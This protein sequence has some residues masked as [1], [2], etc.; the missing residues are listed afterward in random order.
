MN[1]YQLISE[2][3]RYHKFGTAKE[4]FEHI[5]ASGYKGATMNVDGYPLPMGEGFVIE[6][7]HIKRATSLRFSH[8][9]WDKVDKM[10]AH[11]RGD[12]T[13]KTRIDVILRGIRLLEL[14]H[15]FGPVHA[16]TPGG[17]RDF[18]DIEEVIGQF[19]YFEDNDFQP[20]ISQN[21]EKLK[22]G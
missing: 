10:L 9:V 8:E 19:A 22:N 13:V 3:D 7:S 20:L 12:P 17:I 5:E 18:K 21:E 15:R 11:L 6:R 2:D 1:T 16:T 4:I 14:V